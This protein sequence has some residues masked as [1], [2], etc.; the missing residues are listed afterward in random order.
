MITKT[1]CCVHTLEMLLSHVKVPSDLDLIEPLIEH[2][3]DKLKVDLIR[4]KH[5][6]KQMRESFG[7][8]V[9]YLEVRK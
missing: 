8:R 6:V 9:F 7:K 1:D 4:Y 2:Y 3:E 5:Q